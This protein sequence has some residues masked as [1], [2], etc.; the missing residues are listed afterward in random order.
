MENGDP[1]CLEKHIISCEKYAVLIFQYRMKSSFTDLVKIIDT[2]FTSVDCLDIN[3][4]LGGITDIL[5]SLVV[6]Y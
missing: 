1:Q 6:K 5:L 2:I 3:F 4:G